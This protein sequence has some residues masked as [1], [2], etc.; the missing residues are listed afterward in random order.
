MVTK[1]TY[2]KIKGKH[3]ALKTFLALVASMLLAISIQANDTTTNN[4]CEA[5]Y[6][7]CEEKCMSDANVEDKEACLEKCDDTYSKC[8]EKTQEQ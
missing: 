1:K 5:Q 7:T 2:L 3:M 4:D 6:T 8:V